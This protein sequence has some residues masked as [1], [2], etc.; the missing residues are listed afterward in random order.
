MKRITFLS[1]EILT[2]LAVISPSVV[3]QKTN[4]V[5]GINWPQ[6][7][8]SGAPTLTCNATYYGLPY[9]D[10]TNN[11]L[12][13]C[14]PSGWIQMNVGGGCA[15]GTCLQNNPVGSQIWTQPVGTD[16]GISTEVLAIVTP[17]G[18]S[19]ISMS[20][21]F[22]PGGM[23]NHHLS[24]ADGLVYDSTNAA[25]TGITSVGGDTV[26]L[27]S[28]NPII[29]G[30]SSGAPP[31]QVTNLANGTHPSDAVNLSQLA[32][33]GC[34]NCIVNNPANAANQ[35]VAGPLT[36]TCQLA[37]S[38]DIC[39]TAPPYY[40]SINGAT[41]TTGTFAIGTSGTVASCSTF[42][43]NEGLYIAGAAAS[44]ANYIGTV[45][46]CSGTTMTV[47][48]TTATSV[49][50]AVVQHDETAALQSAINALNPSGG[51]IW[52]PDG[53]YLMNGPL[54]DTG[55]ANAIIT[56]PK[57]PN[58]TSPL[59]DIEIRGYTLPN[60]NT[61]GG[62]I[63][64]TA[65][66]AGNFFGGYDA[67]AGGG[68]PPF[69]NVQLQMQRLTIF[70][71]YN[72]TCVAVNATNILAFQGYDLLIRPDATWNGSLPTN[73]NGGLYM[74]AVLNEPTNQLN[75]LTVAGYTNNVIL[76]EHTQ[77][78]KLQ[79][80]LGVNCM[81]ADTGHNAS[82]PGTYFGNSISINSVWAQN[83][84]HMLAAG[85][86]A[87]TI[88][89]QNL[90]SE[91]NTIDIYDPSNDL[92]GYIGFLN[93]F[94]PNTL[95]MTG[96]SN[97]TIFNMWTNG[98]NTPI[99]V[100]F[101]TMQRTAITGGNDSNQGATPTIVAV[102]NTVPTGSA[103]A[104]PAIFIAPNLPTGFAVHW[105]MGHD[106]GT[107]FNAERESFVYYGG[108]GSTS[109]YWWKGI[110]TPGTGAPAGICGN[111]TGQVGIG[112][113]EDSGCPTIAPLTVNGP[114]VDNA[115]WET[116]QGVDIASSTTIA[117]T[118]GLF[119]VSGTA[120]ISTITPPTGMSS[121]VGGCLDV[122]ATGTWSTVTGGNIA[123]VMT[124]VAGVIYHFCYFP[125]QGLWYA[126]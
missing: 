112:F 8:G 77:V 106:G 58:Y 115:N 13:S 123:G 83:C 105:I 36:T 48:P 64:Q 124:A 45:V 44:G 11:N 119:R 43:A 68:S 98:F 35:T 121:T 39:L 49:T 63:F 122:L 103:A 94:S 59:V 26:K 54:Q 19:N 28:T 118:T 116:V 4:P 55:G 107:G 56:I 100:G 120:T 12:Y 85:S 92:H 34:S 69:T 82:A 50:G 57:L 76:T 10:T 23:V 126:K 22:G 90:D 84:T 29:V 62:A 7:T 42:T 17:D 75:N 30:G 71:L 87:T 73:T 125:V 96:G 25:G 37:S 9:T 109:N 16:A 61:Y 86:N 60:P 95:N 102:D 20:K 81:V 6:A 15:E 53:T 108:S 110:H 101:P 97:L 72:A 111:G 117:P 32:S 33:A 99:A 67:A 38:T 40:G 2:L 51:T 31:Q 91:N 65:C 18:L 89:I 52:V 46:S 78:S 41:K 3:A 5:T 47:T 21:Y 24:P 66:P 113:L 93:P 104:A 14:T 114:A 27:L 70:T 74:P 80:V 88:N 79:S 1:L